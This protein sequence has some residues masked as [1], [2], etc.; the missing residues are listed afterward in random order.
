LPK[1]CKTFLSFRLRKRQAL[2][3][4]F[5]CF[6]NTGVTHM[7]VVTL[8]SSNK[9]RLGEIPIVSFTW[10]ENGGTLFSLVCTCRT[11]DLF[12]LL[13]FTLYACFVPHIG[14]FRLY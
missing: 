5:A 11:V 7:G 13:V 2:L 3:R 4:I 6:L 14:E 8:N 9:L 10:A 12:M 1:P